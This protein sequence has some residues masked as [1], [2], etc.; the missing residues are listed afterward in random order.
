MNWTAFWRRWKKRKEGDQNAQNRFSYEN[1]PAD[2][3]MG[4]IMR[5]VFH[6]SGKVCSR[7]IVLEIEDEII[8]KV[9]FIGGCAGNTQGV[10]S[11]VEGMKAEDVIARLEHIPCGNRGSSC[12]AELAVAIRQALAAQDVPAEDA[13]TK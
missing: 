7:G 6:T 4:C 13:E 3:K 2:G 10:A 11:L 9:Q 12:P 8:Q 1:R 5:Y